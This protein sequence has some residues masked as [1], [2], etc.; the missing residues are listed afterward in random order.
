MRRGAKELAT[1]WLFR[2]PAGEMC[3]MLQV[4]FDSLQQWPLDRVWKG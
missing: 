1:K 3:I 4:G 2:V